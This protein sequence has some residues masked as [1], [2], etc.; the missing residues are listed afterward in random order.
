MLVSVIIPCFNVQDFIV[1]CVDSV[2]S[3]TYKVIEIICVDNNSTDNTWKLLTELKQKF[4]QLCLEKEM[5]PGANA[6][7]NKG[8]AIAQ[9]SWIQFLDADDLLLP[10]KIEHQVKLIESNTT[11]L[12]FVAASSFKRKLGGKEIINSVSDNSKYIAAFTNNAGNTCANLWFKH[13]LLLAGRWNNDIKSSQEA[14]MMLR[15]VLSDGEILFD[16]EPL[17]IIRERVSGQISQSNPGDKWLQFIEI[18]L[19]FLGKL[20]TQKPIV[21]QKFKNLY[22]DF[23]MVSVLEL[24]KYNNEK[25]VFFYKKSIKHQWR[26]GGN[27]KF[28]WL[29]VQLIKLIGIKKYVS[30]TS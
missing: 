22:F 11:P 30:L 17:T 4:P 10:N 13:T 3:Q 15:L 24:A 9:G 21:F 5:T 8:L 14:D 7:R 2:M 28:N 16:N 1:E 25:A 23:L 18:R 26:S 20:Q 19:N 27:Y 12:I 6:A 29:K